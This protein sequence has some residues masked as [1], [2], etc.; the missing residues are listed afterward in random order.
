MLHMWWMIYLSTMRRLHHFLILLESNQR[1]KQ[2]CFL[3]LDPCHVVIS[4]DVPNGKVSSFL[5]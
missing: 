1:R 4:K 2:R 3:L 5:M